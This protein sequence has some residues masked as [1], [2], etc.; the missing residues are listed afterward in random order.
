MIKLQV[1]EVK[2]KKSKTIERFKNLGILEAG[3][4]QD[5]AGCFL[6]EKVL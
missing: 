5:G 6:P 1:I 3:T 2:N 4:G